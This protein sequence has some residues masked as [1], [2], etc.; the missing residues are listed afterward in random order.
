MLGPATAPVG[1]AEASR[2]PNGIKGEKRK[3]KFSVS[4][5]IPTR[6]SLAIGTFII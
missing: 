1:A 6:R 5:Y 4:L 3:E 2:I